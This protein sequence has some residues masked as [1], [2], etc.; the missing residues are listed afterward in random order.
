MWP[1]PSPERPQRPPDRPSPPKP[2]EKEAKDRTKDGE[3]ARG[4]DREEMAVAVAAEAGEG[5]A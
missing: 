3:R 1:G 4:A 2:R 5:A